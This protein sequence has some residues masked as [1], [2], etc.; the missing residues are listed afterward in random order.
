MVPNGRK[1]VAT[2]KPRDGSS[3]VWSSVMKSLPRI[4]D[5]L[6]VL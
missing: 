4:D 1:H 3:F 2:S 5:F 6:D